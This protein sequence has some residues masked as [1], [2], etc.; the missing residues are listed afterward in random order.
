[1]AL[2]DTACIPY[3]LSLAEYRPLF[4]LILGQ[5]ILDIK[6]PQDTARICSTPEGAFATA[7]AD[8]AQPE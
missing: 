8:Q 1:M 2:P 4:E 5:G 6:F 7:N 3:K